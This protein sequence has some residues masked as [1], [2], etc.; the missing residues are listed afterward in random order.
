M[1][2]RWLLLGATSVCGLVLSLWSMAA[3]DPT[4]DQP[5]DFNP[6]LAPASA[7]AD[8]AIARFKYANGLQVR[9]WAAE[10]LLAHPVAFCLDEQGRV[11]VAETFRHSDGGATD[12]R[13]HKVW[14]EDDLASRTVADRVAMFKKFLGEKFV[15]YTTQHERIRLVEDIN[16]DGK[17][18]K[19]T[20]FADGFKDPA[21]GIGA[22]VLA[23]AGD[24]YFTCIPDLWR[25]KDTNQN[26]HAEVREK[27]STGYGVHVAFL[28]HDLHGLRMGPDGKLYFSI[29]DRGL[30]V[31]NQ[32]G[33]RLFYPDTGSILRCNP[34]GSELEVIAIG[35]RNP[36]E[37]AFDAYGRLFTGDNNSDSGDKARWVY[38]VEGAD[39]G[40]RM[41]YQYGS[42]MSNRGPWNAEKIWHLPHPEQPAYVLPP[43]AHITAGPSGLCAYYGTGLDERYQDHFFLADFRGS[44]GGSGITSFGI[45]PD[46][47]SFKVTDEHPFIWSILATDCDFGPDGAFYI[48][49]WVEGWNKTG[50]GRIYRLTNP[51]QVTKPAVQQM[52]KLFAEGFVHRSIEELIGL[53][54]HPDLRVRQEAQFAL[55]KQGKAAIAALQRVASESDNV[56][57]RLH[58]IWGL[59]QIGRNQR[60]LAGQAFAPASKLLEH[61]HPE[62]RINAI[63]HL[64]N[65]QYGVTAERLV[66]LL[67]DPEPRVRLHASIALGK[68]LDQDE[69]TLGKAY[70]AIRAFL[71]ENADEDAYLRHGG[72]MALSGL[73]QELIRKAAED[74][75]APVRLAALLSMRQSSDADIAGFLNDADPRLVLEA[76]RAIHDENIDAALPALAGLI[77]RSLEDTNLGFRVLNAHFRLGQPENARALAAFAAWP[78]AKEPLRL[79]ALSMLGAWA[80][81]GRRDRITGATQELPARSAEVATTALRTQLGRLFTGSGKVRQEAAKVAAKLGIQEISPVLFE[82]LQDAKQ[83]GK[84]RVDALEALEALKDPKLSEA[85]ASAEQA[86]DPRLRNA[87][88]RLRATS[89]PEAV[90]AQLAQVIANPKTS[91]L[92]IQGSYRLLGGLDQPAADRLLEAGLDR[93]LA[94]KILP[95]ARLDL[96]QAA[97]KRAVKRPSL[98]RKLAAYNQARP[99]NDPLADY[100]E[101]LAGGDAEVGRQIFF[102]DEQ[103]YCLRCHMVEGVGGVV[104][105]ALDAIGSKK[106]RRYL[107]E[108]IV[109]PSANIAEG[110]DT[111]TLFLLDGRSVSGVLKG[112]NEQQVKLIT[113]EGKMLTIAKEDIDLRQKGQ[114]AMPV[115]LLKHLPK[116]KLRD[117]VEYLASLKAKE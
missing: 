61:P 88:R 117:L 106:D 89:K 68:R 8:Q 26:G 16:G 20:V 113:A 17:A 50:K 103:V 79:E 60:T 114:S 70:A 96:L 73:P 3:V 49:D 104:G 115:D 1:H 40:W 54:E 62:V 99:A 2:S 53:F 67:A 84:V 78:T 43:C 24:V 12:N 4:S 75:A 93:L 80:K 97:R 5:S 72:V 112:E 91:V 108:A 81:P 22:G 25:L 35:L 95:E 92:E 23:R 58:A 42:S 77:R 21:A 29:G 34:D 64:G 7:E 107:L 83:P 41:Y 38:V 57:A 111:V 66:P 11:Y 37:L 45:E 19:A 74:D 109:M 13:D 100:L 44:S 39:S 105:P 102:N 30:N 31:V 51:T 48:S 46:G 14:L 101:T 76:A 110:Y 52:Q 18:D 6:K 82:L 56:F 15:D 86:N 32:E 9:T 36:Q 63:K 10:P 65:R 69:Q 87:G 71:V 27:L 59:G 85:I 28:G 116:P 90:I 33:K 55:A 47:A 94:G 98:E